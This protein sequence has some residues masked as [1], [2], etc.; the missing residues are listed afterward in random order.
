MANIAKILQEIKELSLE[1]FLLLEEKFGKEAKFR[2]EEIH[3]EA[4]N[5][6]SVCPHCGSN[7]IIKWGKAK[8]KQRYQC[9]KCQSTFSTTTGTVIHW[10]KKPEEF[11]KFCVSMFTD[12]FKPLSEQSIN[13]DISVS[14]AFEWRHKALIAMGEESPIFQGETEID[15][16]WFRY[17]QKG[18]KGLKY[19]RERGRSS[20]KGD[21]NFSC[22]VLM[23]KERKGAF[24]IA[25]VKIGRLDIA[26][27]K[28][29]LG[30]KFEKTAIINSDKHPSII[31]F[32]KEENID[33]KTFKSNQHSSNPQTHVQ[34]INNLAS[35]FDTGINRLL[36]GVSTKYLQNYATWF[37][38]QERNKNE[39]NQLKEWIKI[40][41]SNIKA[42]D[43]FTNIEQ[44]YEVFLKEKSKRTY[45]CPTLKYRKYQN[46]NFENAK[47]GI[48]I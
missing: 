4:T 34:T 44:L 19:S 15:D 35:R 39:E 47:S 31:G 17:S 29:R 16:I 48:F 41:F 23:T 25:L 26:T 22:K 27:L 10:L 2:Q 12:E 32:A 7:Q 38:I 33:Y 13:S 11:L 36:R 5:N 37:K 8:E 9:K 30:G 1:N 40:C 21:N 46:W 6:V 3:K 18:R 42:W 20:H 14:T 45:R 43:M 28:Q 24:D